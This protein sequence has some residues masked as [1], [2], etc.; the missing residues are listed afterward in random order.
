MEACPFPFPA[1]S[2][3]DTLIQLDDGDTLLSRVAYL[4]HAS[5]VFEM[6]LRCEPDGTLCQ[7]TSC[8]HTLPVS[9]GFRLPLPGVSRHQVE[10]LLCCLSCWMRETWAASLSLADLWD[11]ARV[12]HKFSCSLVLQLVDCTL[13]RRCTDGQAA[14]HSGTDR[15]SGPDAAACVSL[16][17]SS[18]PEHSR[19]AH[20]LGLVE[21]EACVGAYIGRHAAEIDL[22]KL[23]PMSANILRGALEARAALFQSMQH[24]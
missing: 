5:E 19:L 8:G 9:I 22:D 12:A 14:G 4:E 15:T 10:L 17:P 7:H 6:A 24:A 1:W 18:A 23:E 3:P 21:Y 13:V 2:T 20:D 11:L 16:A